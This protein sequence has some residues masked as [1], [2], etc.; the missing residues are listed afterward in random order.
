MWFSDLR[1]YYLV[2]LNETIPMKPRHVMWPRSSNDRKWLLFTLLLQSIKSRNWVNSAES[3]MD[4]FSVSQR[5]S[6]TFC[7]CH[8]TI[9]SHRASL[10]SS[11]SVH[12]MVGFRIASYQKTHSELVKR[13]FWHRENFGYTKF[14][15]QVK[16][17]SRWRPEHYLHPHQTSQWPLML[18]VWGVGSPWQRP[19]PLG[20]KHFTGE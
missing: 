14:D 11:Y 9:C 15:N 10:A 13:N 5:V 2:P 4:I 8:K 3:N 6:F 20:Q 17:C 19:R 16:V 12:L 18:Y 7:H 1:S